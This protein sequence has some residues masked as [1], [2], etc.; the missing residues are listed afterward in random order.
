MFVV[1]LQQWVRTLALPNATAPD[2][3][4]ADRMARWLSLRV[5]SLWFIW[6]CLSIGI[7][8][9]EVVL[10]QTSTEEYLEEK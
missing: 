6:P 7:I 3:F 1:P 4:C 10:G 9:E 2:W 5:K 8:E